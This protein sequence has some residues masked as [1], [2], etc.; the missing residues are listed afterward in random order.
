MLVFS[1][2]TPHPPI[3]IENIGKESIEKIKK[4]QNALVELEEELYTAKPDIIIII[5]PHGEIHPDYF[6][7][8]LHP[9]YEGDFKEFGDFI[10]KLSFKGNIQFVHQI[11]NEVENKIPLTLISSPILDHGS[12]VPLYYLTKH[13]P[14]VNIVPVSYSFLDFNK[15]IVLGQIIKRVILKS[16]KRV[17]VIAS[18]DLS[19]RLTKTAPAGYS[20]VGKVF[21]KKL[22]RALETKNT[23]EIFAFDNQFI[24]QAG[25]CGLRSFLILL[26]ILSKINYQPKVLSYE[27]SFGVGY[28]VMNFILK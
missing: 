23:E 20:P 26:G 9:Y 18:G 27:G 17:A 2:I 16:N 10:T 24:E 14:K 28:L 7:I 15:H 12:M 19:H 13:L 8:N 5:S 11:K 6:T 22:I 1:C 4:T 25:E 3:L 21:D